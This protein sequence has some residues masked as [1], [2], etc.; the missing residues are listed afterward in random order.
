M[1]ETAFRYWGAANMFEKY[2]LK[3]EG[4]YDVGTW[5][6]GVGFPPTHSEKASCYV[7]LP[8]VNAVEKLLDLYNG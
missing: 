2:K 8:T 5:G 1:E 7:M 6:L 3:G 4:F